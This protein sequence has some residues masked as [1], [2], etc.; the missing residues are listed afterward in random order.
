MRSRLLAAVWHRRG[1]HLV[2]A[3]AIAV[4]AGGSAVV[5][6]DGSD[7]GLVAPLLILAAGTVPTAGQALGSRRRHEAALLRLRGRRGWSLGLALAAEPLVPVIVGGAAGV[8]AAWSMTPGRSVFA[9]AVVAGAAVVVV[10]AML[11]ALREP[12]PAQLGE[13]RRSLGDGQAKRF[14][15]ILVVV[16]AVV[17]V[18]R[19]DSDGP[20]WLPYAGPTLVGLAAGVVALGA[21]RAAARWL[22]GR[23]GLGSVLIGRRLAAPGATAGLPVLVAAGTL[24]GLAANTL[25]AVQAWEEDTRLVTAGAPLVVR[26]AGDPDDVLAATREADPAGRWLL[27]AVRVFADDRPV[28][29][30]VY[31]DTARYDTVVGDRLDDTPAAD[32][33]AAIAALHE[34]ATTAEPEPLTTGKFLTATMS[35]DSE[36]GEFALIS[37]STDGVQGGAQQ[38]LFLYLPRLQSTTTFVP[39][40]RCDFGCRVVGL[41]VAVGRPCGASTYARPRCRRPLVRISRLNI[42]GIDL[43]DRELTVSEPDDRPPG[44]LVAAEDHLELRPSVAGSSLLAIDRSRW[45]APLL[46]TTNVTWE[47]E[48]EAP[49]TSGLPRPGRVL[50]TVPA[51]PLVGAGGTVLDLPTSTLEGGSFGASAEAWVLAR[52][53]TPG[54]VLARVGTPVTPTDLSAATIEDS[55]SDLARDL[56]AIALGGLALGILG[57]VLPA[58]RLRRERTRELAALRVVGIDTGVLRRTARAQSAL[59]ATAAAVAT[60]LGT[61]AAVA[62]FAEVVPILRP[63]PAQLPLDTGMHPLPMVLAGVAVLAVALV[64]GRWTSGS[65]GAASRPATLSEGDAG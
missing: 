15:G 60:A 51:L 54:D 35:T 4:V 44:E 23:P 61:A 7:R 64:A 13:R 37:V 19:R 39:L 48:P 20:G 65:R 43:L 9:I 53:D 28:A 34:A 52:R 16:A 36:R 62:A 29:R 17:A 2:L 47:G 63:Q 5:T 57:I 3:A 1:T 42:G 24:L 40:T 30:R 55:G 21:L 45:S 27:P 49:T 26:Y 6:A 8:G 12:L 46:A 50:A 32:G 22:A 14:V 31:L 41:E 18:L 33:S 38:E 58:P 56:L 25:L 10:V 11:V 59:V